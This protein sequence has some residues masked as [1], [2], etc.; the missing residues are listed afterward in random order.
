VRT[1]SI[2]A[3]LRQVLKECKG[4]RINLGGHDVSEAPIGLTIAEKFFGLLII[5]LG[6][7][8]SYVTYSNPPE[9]VVSQFSGFFTLTG[10]VL[11]AVG[12]FLVLSKSE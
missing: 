1:P 9:G 7:I 8:I 10:F 5:L 12:I 3:F 4:T 2:T 11:I 6:I